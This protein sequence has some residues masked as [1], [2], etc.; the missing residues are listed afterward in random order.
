MNAQMVMSTPALDLK[1]S[2]LRVW[3]KDFISRQRF[4]QKQARR[5]APDTRGGH[6]GAAAESGDADTGCGLG[7]RSQPLC[8]GLLVISSLRTMLLGLGL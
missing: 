6:F 3:L 5:R 1:D 8:L 2:L 7:G 4:V